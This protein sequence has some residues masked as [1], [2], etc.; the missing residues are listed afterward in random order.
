MNEG[1]DTDRRLEEL[2]SNYNHL[3]EAVQTRFLG[4]HEVVE[5]LLINVLAG[6]HVL[7]EGAPGLGKTLLVQTLAKAT[8][9][10]FRRIQFTPDLM[11]PDIL[12]ARILEE[13]E[14]GHRRFNFEPGPIFSQ[15]VLADEI[16]RATPRTQSALLEAMQE[17]QVTIFG[18][19]RT[20]E[21]P[22]FV[23]ATQNPIE[24]EGTYPLPEAQLDRFL[25]KIILAAPD[26]DELV[27]ILGAT[28]GQLAADP[29]AIVDAQKI[30]DMQSL[31]REVPV[32]SDILGLVAKLIRCTHPS[33]ANAP[34]SIKRMARF[35]SSP[36]GG[37]ALIMASK[38]RALIYGRLFVSEEDLEALA[39]PTLR[40]RLIRSYEGEA[41]RVNP[42]AL[43]KDAFAA[44][45]KL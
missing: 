38:A 32:S 9:L 37:Q 14:D 12:G 26:Q 16:N 27:K 42:D 34:E 3:A 28:T 5:E 23:I 21:E 1:I 35:G 36:R 11:P 6:G 39:A 7:L 8:G 44:A 18:E 20:L 22:F 17:G 43:V 29:V 40:H 41:A 13:T 15:I 19:T 10:G 30:L 24:M 25:L 33:E 4:Q 31:V 45:L 2:R